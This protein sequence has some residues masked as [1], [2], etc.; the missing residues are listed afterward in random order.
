MN[1]N[2]QFLSDFLSNLNGFS[3]IKPRNESIK[4]RKTK[5]QHTASKLYNEFLDIYFDE[6]YDLSDA[7]KRIRA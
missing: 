1:Q 3:N 4:N 6:Y 5:V 7:K 2:S